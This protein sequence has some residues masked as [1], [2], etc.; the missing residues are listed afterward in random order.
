MAE[1]QPLIVDPII[2]TLLKLEPKEIVNACQINRFYADICRNNP[3]IWS[4]RL[5]SDFGVTITTLTDLTPREIWN[6]VYYLSQLNT[7]NLRKLNWEFVSAA[8]KGYNDLI[9]YILRRKVEL[10]SESLNGDPETFY[11]EVIKIAIDEDNLDLFK[12]LYDQASQNLSTPFR[13][14][15]IENY[16]YTAVLRAAESNK[17]EL[18]NSLVSMIDN[19]DYDVLLP[20]IIQTNNV[21][22]TRILIASYLNKYS[23]NERLM[24]FLKQEMGR[25]AFNGNFEIIKYLNSIGVEITDDTIAKVQLPGPFPKSRSPEFQQKKQQIVNYLIESKTT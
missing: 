17:V 10:A 16:A 14:Q 4:Q 1:N 21:E 6:Y 8:Q 12:I 7:D 3:F 15:I 13:Q 9:P 25:A 23:N 11:D 5:K 22:A 20:Q 24:N 2:E 19:V 18:L